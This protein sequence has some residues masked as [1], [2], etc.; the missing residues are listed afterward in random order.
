MTVPYWEVYSALKAIRPLGLSISV[1]RQPDASVH[2]EAI[3]RYRDQQRSF[4]TIVAGGADRSILGPLRES[5]V[6]LVQS[7]E[8]DVDGVVETI[9]ETL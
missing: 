4:R 5:L 3:H 8:A 1:T 6:D 7:I 9:D 2:V